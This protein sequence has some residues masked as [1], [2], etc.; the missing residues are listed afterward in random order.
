MTSRPGRGKA[1]PTDEEQGVREHCRNEHIGSGRG[2]IRY[3]RLLHHR[4]A[5]L[6]LEIAFKQI[7][8]S[9]ELKPETCEHCKQ[10]KCQCPAFELETPCPSASSTPMHSSTDDE[11]VPQ[12]VPNTETHVLYP[13]VLSPSD[14]EADL[15]VAAICRR[16]VPYRMIQSRTRRWRFYMYNSLDAVAENRGQKRRRDDSPPYRRDSEYF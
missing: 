15:E 12:L 16:P 14:E 2:A 3:S 8:I 11:E 1:A 4:C 13:P 5:S 9:P 10:E 7:K 6:D